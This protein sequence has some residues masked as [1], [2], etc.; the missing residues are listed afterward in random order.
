MIDGNGCE[1]IMCTVTFETEMILNE[2]EYSDRTGKWLTKYNSNGKSDDNIWPFVECKN[3]KQ[4]P[5]NRKA[6]KRSCKVNMKNVQTNFKTN[7]LQTGFP[8]E[9]IS[10]KAITIIDDQPD[11]KLIGEMKW[12]GTK[13]KQVFKYYQDKDG[14]GAK[15][16]EATAYK[17]MIPY[18]YIQ[19]CDETQK[20]LEK[21]RTQIGLGINGQDEDNGTDN[22]TE[23]DGFKTA[24][25]TRNN[26]TAILTTG[27][28]T[29]NTMINIIEKSKENEQ[30]QGNA[31]RISSTRVKPQ[32][33]CHGN[34]LTTNME[35]P[36][37]GE[38]NVQKPRSEEVNCR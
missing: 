23:E 33:L 2:T 9:T 35:H 5:H 20:I 29:D 36:E 37:V 15:I 28:S 6:N 27:A 13:Y 8:Y 18:L 38:C 24:P 16:P 31:P 25:S 14:K 17:V 12:A 19:G 10:F 4:I 11:T 22:D 30:E 21:F 34:Y 32:L 1:M 26:A 7:K 3:R